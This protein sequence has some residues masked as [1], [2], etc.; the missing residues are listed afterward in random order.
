METAK[1]ACDKNIGPTTEMLRLSISLG[2]LQTAV[3][4]TGPGRLKSVAF[5][6]NKKV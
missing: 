3:Y 4:T 6:H 1:T 5:A 2:L